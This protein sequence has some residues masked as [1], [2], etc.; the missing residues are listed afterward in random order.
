MR[1]ALIA[2]EYQGLIEKLPNQ[3]ARI[4]NLDAENIR[5]LF[6]DMSMLELETVK[7]LPA[8]KLGRLASAE[9]PADFHRYLYGNTASSL[10][11][12]F[13]RIITETYITFILEHADGSKIFPAFENLKHSVKDF[14]EL[15]ASYSVYA[16]SLADELIHVRTHKE[17]SQC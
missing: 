8:E 13:L 16:D 5:N 15:E 2:L 17:E 4:I 3:H 10:R 7:S 9:N 11:R 12:I 6:A 14:A 1:E